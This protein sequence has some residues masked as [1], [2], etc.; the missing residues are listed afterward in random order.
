MTH[1]IWV[2]LKRFRKD[3][4]TEPDD[5]ADAEQDAELEDSLIF[6]ILPNDKKWV[7]NQG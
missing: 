3:V 2:I 4:E 6:G 1:I 7:S 5:G